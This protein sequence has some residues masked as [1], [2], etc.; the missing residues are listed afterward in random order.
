LLDVLYPA[1]DLANRQ[2]TASLLSRR[3]NFGEFAFQAL[4]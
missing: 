2:R 1:D 4:Q 3:P